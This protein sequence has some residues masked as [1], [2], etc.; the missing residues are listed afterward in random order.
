MAYDMEEDEEYTVYTGHWSD[1]KRQG[2]GIEYAKSEKWVYAIYD[3][4]W[5]EGLRDGQGTEFELN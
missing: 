1:G 2:R 4:E 5:L 3:G